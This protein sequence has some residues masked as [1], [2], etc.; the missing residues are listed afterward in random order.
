[1]RVSLLISVV[2]ACAVL[3]GCNDQEAENRAKLAEE[4]A[5]AAEK[6]AAV[7]EEKLLI[8][9]KQL[10]EDAERAK[11]EAQAKE[12]RYRKSKDIDWLK[13]FR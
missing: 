11:R 13:E 2:L 4:R 1:M 5:V 3:T 6:R 9:E 12:N 10:S 7:A 8:L